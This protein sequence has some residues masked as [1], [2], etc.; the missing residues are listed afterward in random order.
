M[1]AQPSVCM[2]FT[3]RSELKSCK[4][5]DMVNFYSDKTGCRR[6]LL[7]KSIGDMHTTPS[8]RNMCCDKCARSNPYL[9]LR[10]FDPAKVPRKDKSSKVRT[11]PNDVVTEVRNKL[12]EACSTIFTQRIGMR[13][14]V[15]DVVCPASCVNDI[16]NKANFINSKED[17]GVIAGL[18][19][20]FA[21]NFFNVFME[22]INTMYM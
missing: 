16:C 7:L 3:N 8:P 18:R 5:K 12:M 20:K 21:E 15:L 22:V 14:L 11:L 19:A 17:L 1:D 2:L 6:K 4:D 13:A 10:F 9:H